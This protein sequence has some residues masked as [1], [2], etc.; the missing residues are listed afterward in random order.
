M[1]SKELRKDGARSFL[2]VF[3]TGDEFPRD[4]IAFASANAIRAGHFTA[5]GAFTDFTIAYWNREVV[6]YEKNR[7]Q[8]QVEVT[9]L[10]GNIAVDAQG[11]TKVHAHVTLGRRDFTTIA[12]HLM[13]AVVRPTLEV[14]LTEEP[15]EVVRRV[16]EETKLTLIDLPA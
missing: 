16:D 7:M 12:G 3:E 10:V 5:I 9:A 1:R 4:L 14:Y 2:L 8:E 6:E 15:G 13:E 11:E